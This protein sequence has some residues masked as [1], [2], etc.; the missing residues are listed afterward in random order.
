MRYFL[1]FF[2]FLFQFC[3]P[4]AH[5]N[6]PVLT[7]NIPVFDEDT[8][9]EQGIFTG[10]KG[11]GEYQ[12]TEFG[13]FRLISCSGGI[14]KDNALFLMV[15]GL[16]FDGW[17]LQKPVIPYSVDEKILKEDISYP[18]A[19]LNEKHFS[20]NEKSRCRVHLLFFCIASCK[21]QSFVI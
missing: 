5:A 2:C 14:P 7:S 16:L 21:S 8:I 13:R 18:I 4:F 12:K 19:D 10:R 9:I 15:E 6:E 20:K 17:V 1:I 11:L 3:M